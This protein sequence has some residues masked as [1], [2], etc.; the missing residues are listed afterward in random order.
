MDYSWRK[1]QLIIKEAVDWV[2]RQP[3]CPQIQLAPPG[4][5]PNL[6]IFLRVNFMFLAVPSCTM[7]SCIGNCANRSVRGLG[8]EAAAARASGM[9]PKSLGDNHTRRKLPQGPASTP[10]TWNLP[11]CCC[12]ASCRHH[13]WQQPS[14]L[15]VC[16]VLSI[17][18]G[19]GATSPTPQDCRWGGWAVG[20]GQPPADTLAGTGAV[21]KEASPVSD[22]HIRTPP[23]EDR[24][25]ALGRRGLDLGCQEEHKIQ[26]CGVSGSDLHTWA[27]T[28]VLGLVCSALEWLFK[29]VSAA[30]LS[31]HDPCG[32]LEMFLVLRGPRPRGLQELCLASVSAIATAWSSLLWDCAC[33][34]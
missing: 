14:S 1:R 22:W 20:C 24:S 18:A 29:M 8:S 32:G 12:C 33:F 3:N 13:L 9:C 28:G 10:W 25:S 11:W 6:G 31:L 34:R 27:S 2:D 19:F 23:A 21:E 16:P 4:N 26:S 5:I 17:L 7:A 30:S 15:G